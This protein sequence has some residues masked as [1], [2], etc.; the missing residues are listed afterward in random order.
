MVRRA[1]RLGTVV[2]GLAAVGEAG[3]VLLERSGW[4][5]AHHVFHVAYLG[6]AAVA[7]GWFAA[8]DLRRHGP[9]RFSWSL[10]ADEAPRPSR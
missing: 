8:R 9:P 3:H 4:A 10:R 5:A 2:A 1:I 7:F 6:A